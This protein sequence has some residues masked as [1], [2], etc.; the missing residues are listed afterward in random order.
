V[1]RTALIISACR[2]RKGGE[3][4]GSVVSGVLVRL[5]L[6]LLGKAISMLDYG[7]LLYL[8]HPIEG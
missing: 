6:A 5:F 1:H 7:L 3:M 8:S 4:L 2:G